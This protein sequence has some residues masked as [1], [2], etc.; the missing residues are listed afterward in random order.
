MVVVVSARGCWAFIILDLDYRDGPQGSR[1]PTHPYS[2]GGLGTCQRPD[3]GR[4]T[5][6]V[7]PLVGAVDRL[8]GCLMGFRCSSWP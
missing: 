7:P 8:M 6:H 3:P 2:R 1:L 5:E 4:R